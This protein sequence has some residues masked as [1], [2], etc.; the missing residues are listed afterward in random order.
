[1]GGS[2]VRPPSD[3]IVETLR[4]IGG[5]SGPLDDKGVESRLRVTPNRWIAKDLAPPIDTKTPMAWLSVREFDLAHALGFASSLREAMSKR[6]ENG[7]AFERGLS[8]V[9]ARESDRLTTYD[10]CIDGEFS[11][12]DH[13]GVATP[14]SLETYAI[15]PFR[16]FARSVLWLKQLDD[17]ALQ[18]SLDP[19]DSGDL[20]HR[21]LAAVFGRLSSEE[22]FPL[23]EKSLDDL[24]SQLD[25]WTDE[26]LFGTKDRVWPAHMP[27]VARDNERQRLLTI[28]KR[29]LSD[30]VEESAESWVPAQFE[31]AFGID[32]KRRGEGGDGWSVEQPVEL[33]GGDGLT[34]RGRID[35]IDVGDDSQSA[36]IIDYKS[37]SPPQD[38]GRAGPFAGGVRLQLAAY[39]L[40]AEKVLGEKAPG[41]NSIE[42]SYWF[43]REPG[44]RYE[45]L[46]HLN[47]E[48]D[49]ITQAFGEVVSA[50]VSGIS[51]GSF[52]AHP[53]KDP[54]HHS[55]C[56]WCDYKEMCGPVGPIEL[57]RAAT[58]SDERVEKFWEM[59]RKHA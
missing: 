23:T 45:K 48:S 40:G 57:R 33:P 5:D 1:M 43:L 6:R 36:R 58:K 8:A 9:E 12:G 44:H 21:M 14:T 32:S 49:E 53:Y 25:S 37:G 28:L 11:V 20:V 50:I 59:R 4:Q 19:R 24:L 38:A 2:T 39:L 15:C 55:M 56:R 7:M 54:S 16:Y 52:P 10:G 27:P 42:A 13:Q 35:R 30:G 51:S 46:R 26:H 31:V 29:V 3:V 41:V 17:P 22:R 34:A 47:Q 18:L